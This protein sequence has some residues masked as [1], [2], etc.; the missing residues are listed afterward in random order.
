MIKKIKLAILLTMVLLLSMS[1]L[2]SSSMNSK[3]EHLVTEFVQGLV[4]G[5]DFEQVSHLFLSV[6]DHEGLMQALK[7][8]SKNYRKH[9]VKRFVNTMAKNW[10]KI[11]GP[12][13]K[14]DIQLSYQGFSNKEKSKK[15]VTRYHLSIKFLMIKNKRKKDIKKEIVVMDIGGKLKIVHLFNRF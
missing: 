10:R 2:S 8:A 12:V 4:H 1:S 13:K 14:E 11:T 5:S 6:E 7:I 9:E 3:Q 15:G